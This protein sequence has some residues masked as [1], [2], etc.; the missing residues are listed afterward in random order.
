MAKRS[1]GDDLDRDVVDFVCAFLEMTRPS[2][3]AGTPHHERSLPLRNS[4]RGRA[5]AH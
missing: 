4:T 5:D 3:T 2:P 1:S